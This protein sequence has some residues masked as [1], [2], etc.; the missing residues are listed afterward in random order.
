MRINKKGDS[1]ML[2]EI[3]KN[4]LENAEVFAYALSVMYGTDYKPAM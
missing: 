1:K 2:K 4:L 3:K